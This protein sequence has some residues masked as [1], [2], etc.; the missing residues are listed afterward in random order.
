MF[1]FILSFFAGY[2]LSFG[3]VRLTIRLSA[4]AG[5]HIGYRCSRSCVEDVTNTNVIIKTQDRKWDW[6]AN[7]VMPGS[8]GLGIL[9]IFEKKAVS[10]DLTLD[11]ASWDSDLDESSVDYGMRAR[12]LGQWVEIWRW[13]KRVD[14]DLGEASPVGSMGCAARFW[15]RWNSQ[16]IKNCVSL[17]PRV[18]PELKRV[19]S[20]S[21]ISGFLWIWTFYISVFFTHSYN[22]YT[23][24]G[25]DLSYFVSPAARFISLSFFLF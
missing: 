13:T 14:L 10:W 17:S 12:L 18:V 6:G 9:V 25:A 2:I 11:E 3:L 5:A 4:R 20:V 24:I 16:H 15:V 8:D 7:D 22:G 23:T 19:V 1:F 21:R